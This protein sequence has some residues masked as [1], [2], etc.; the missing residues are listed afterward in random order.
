M[1][2]VSA[3]VASLAA[4]NALCLYRCLFAR[5][6]ED[7]RIKKKPFVCRVASQTDLQ[8]S[9]NIMLGSWRQRM[10]C[11]PHRSGLPVV[12]LKI[13][14]SICVT[15]RSVKI[16]N[17]RMPQQV[18][19]STF[20]QALVLPSFRCP[21][22]QEVMRERNTGKRSITA[23]QCSDEWRTLGT[24]ALLALLALLHFQEP[25]VTSD[26][27]TYE[28]QN[29]QERAVKLYPFLFKRFAFLDCISNHFNLPSCKNV[30]RFF[31][32]NL[33]PTLLIRFELSLVCQEWFRRGTQTS[34]LTNLPL[35]SKEFLPNLAL[36]QVLLRDVSIL[37]VDENVWK[38]H[39]HGHQLEGS[40]RFSHQSVSGAAGGRN[41]LTS[42][43]NR[44]C[45]RM[46]FCFYS[47]L[48]GRNLRIASAWNRE[49]RC[50]AEWQNGSGL[51]CK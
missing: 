4:G 45:L 13:L 24:F 31:F 46:S 36:R 35:D 44:L 12:F 40:G 19:V 49:W 11:R 41:G 47:V 9:G 51:P 30:T 20:V 25:V 23:S 33:N 3:A 22:S 8:R 21:I 27:Q 28:R 1:V 42:S 29:I 18:W 16:F 34:P 50:G 48:T 43:F 38:H 5:C 26:G 6:R 10:I 39:E 14:S 32:W 15:L 37:D 17:N 2:I 7:G